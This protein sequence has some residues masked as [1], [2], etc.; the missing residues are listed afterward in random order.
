[1]ATAVIGTSIGGAMAN[2]GTI[3]VTMMT[4][5]IDTGIDM[6]IRTIEGI[7]VEV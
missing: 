2:T 6:A 3:V 1:M 4:V 7:G 5:V